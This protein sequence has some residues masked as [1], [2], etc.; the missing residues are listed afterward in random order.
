[1]ERAQ[2]RTPHNPRQPQ[3]WP[4]P[5][6][7]RVGYIRHLAEGTTRRA[8]ANKEAIEYFASIGVHYEGL[9]DG[10]N[11]VR[12]REIES[13]LPTVRKARFRKRSATGTLLG[14]LTIQGEAAQI[15]EPTTDKGVN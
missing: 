13:E 10:Y 6:R 7:P 4:Q 3:D 15:S 5:D 12:P 9:P 8:T 14:S 2:H 1:M 11:F